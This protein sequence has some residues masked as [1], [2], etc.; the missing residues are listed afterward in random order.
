[1]VQKLGAVVDR[2]RGSKSQGKVT[3]Y[4]FILKHSNIA[5]I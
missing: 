2:V 3:S 4:S 1:M 5:R